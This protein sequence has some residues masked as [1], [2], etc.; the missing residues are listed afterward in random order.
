[1]YE[2][3][4]LV[5]AWLRGC[6][7]CA[8]TLNSKWN[9]G[10]VYE[11]AIHY[12]LECL[13]YLNEWIALKFKINHRL[14]NKK[15]QIMSKLYVQEQSVWFLEAIYKVVYP[16]AQDVHFCC[17]VS[18]WYVPTGTQNT[19]TIVPICISWTNSY[20]LKYIDFVI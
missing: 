1:M 12:I 15:C 11:D 5:F 8:I 13:L 20:K 6:I 17:P 2:T 4:I 16:P 10:A 3:F 14:C 18:S 19:Q 7:L 9:C